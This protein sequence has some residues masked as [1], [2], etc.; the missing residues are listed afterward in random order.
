MAVLRDLRE[1][2]VSA[3]E[4]PERS[5]KE[6]LRIAQILRLLPNAGPGTPA[7]IEPIH[8]ARGLIACL[9]VDRAVHA[10]E[11][12]QMYGPMVCKSIDLRSGLN[13]RDLDDRVEVLSFLARK[14]GGSSKPNLKTLRSIEFEDVIAHLIEFTGTDEGEKHSV[15]GMPV[16]EIERAR[17]LAGEINVGDVRAFYGSDSALGLRP[18]MPR[19]PGYSLKARVDG[20][21][22]RQ[23]GLIFRT[24]EPQTA[25]P[26]SKSSK[27]DRE[28]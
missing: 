28:T 4:M 25:T 20:H 17:A 5:V 10:G 16:I 3:L 14:T 21:I 9:G 6:R 26:Q 19:R 27:Q 2:L 1:V 7:K 18:W 12:I 11:A 15:I 13:E 8:A 23:I 24:Q 22:L